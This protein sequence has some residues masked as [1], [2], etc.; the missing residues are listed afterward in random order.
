MKELIKDMP[1]WDLVNMINEI[2]I[3]YANTEDF[4]KHAPT[5]KLR[6]TLRADGAY[7]LE[8]YD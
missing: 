3:R 2:M 8:L 7:D 4:K 6:C 5:A 1:F